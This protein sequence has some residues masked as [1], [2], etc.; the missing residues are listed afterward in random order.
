MCSNPWPTVS[1]SLIQHNTIVLIIV[2]VI[3][4]RYY[5][6]V[7][8]FMRFPDETS[9]MSLLIYPESFTGNKIILQWLYIIIHSVYKFN[10]EYRI[11]RE[12]K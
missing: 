12:K 5:S 3:D 11:L 8:G 7:V 6:C 9:N 1:L 10:T 2:L 4:D